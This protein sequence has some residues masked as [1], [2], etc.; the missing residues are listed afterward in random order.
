VQDTLK[1]ATET[2]SSSP[3]GGSPVLAGLAGITEIKRTLQR[4]SSYQ[5]RTLLVL[6]LRNPDHKLIYRPREPAGRQKIAAQSHEETIASS[7]CE[8]Q[9]TN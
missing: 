7:L 2:G 1:V 6:P 5:I 9:I 4:T 3:T 8:T